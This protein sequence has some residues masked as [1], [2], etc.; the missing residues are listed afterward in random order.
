MKVLV[1]S[2]HPDDETL[3]CAGTI[4]KHKNNGDSVHWII[5][6]SPHTPAWSDETIARKKQEIETVSATYNMDNVYKLGFP[7]A[8]LETL[9]LTEI[10][11]ALETRISEINPDVVYLV[12]GGDIHS[13]HRVTFNAATSAIKSFKMADLGIKRILCFET[14]SSTEAGPQIPVSAFTP[15]VF[16]DISD[17]I[18]QKIEIMNLYATEVQDDPLPRGPAAIKALARYRGA[19]IGVQY[20]EAFM[21]IRELI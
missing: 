10:I 4:L 12:H 20:A 13:D 15:N 3:G 21:L 8:M 11:K 14:L 2:T 19:T 5:A 9:P 6:T 18:D 16:V 1:I 7:A 17:F